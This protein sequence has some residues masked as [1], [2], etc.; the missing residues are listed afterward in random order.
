MGKA[1]ANFGHTLDNSLFDGSRISNPL[2]VCV[3]GGAGYVGLITGVG[4]AELGHQVVNMDVDTGLLELLQQGT[5][6]IYEEGLET[7]LRRNLESRRLRFSDNFSESVSSSEVVL[8]AVGTPSRDDGQADLSQVIRVAEELVQCL[9]NYTVVAIKSTVPVGTVELVQSILRREKREGCDFDI[10]SNPE[11]LREGKGIEDFFHPDRLV[12]GTCS[13]RALN[14]MRDLYRPLI[15][16]NFGEC[17]SRSAIDLTPW[18][19]TDLTSAQMIKYASNAFLATRI[20]FVNEIAG[21][22]ERLGANVKEVTRG[23]GFDPRIGHHY[24]EAGLGFGGPCLEKD[25]RALIR[26]A[27]GVDYDP[28]VLR[29]VLD[30]NERQLEDV[31]AKLKSF[32]GYLIYR[33]IF[34][35]F[36]LAFKAGT[37]D[38]RNSLSIK[39]VDRLVEEGAIVRAFDPVAI[40]EAR[41]LRPEV[42]YYEDPYQSVKDADALL[43]LTDWQQFQELDYDYI[44]DAMANPFVLDARNILNP[45]SLRAMGIS[46]VGMGLS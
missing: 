40:P 27:E 26:I 35:L 12:V 5:S 45:E 38:V 34:T 6:P 9:E 4:L 13:Q 44:R 20:S 46:Y 30:R 29:S 18:V 37:N 2:N 8:I 41:K 15:E 23:M 25:L 33:K 1:E 39:L 14:V 16:N 21:M 31:I 3:V 10:V 42:I 43:I 24:L 36:G 17:D 28:R 7:V 19:E 22:C 11:F 32:S